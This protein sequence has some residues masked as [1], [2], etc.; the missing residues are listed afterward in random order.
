MVFSGI[1]GPKRLVLC[2]TENINNNQ[3][4]DRAKLSNRQFFLKLYMRIHP[5]VTFAEQTSQKLSLQRIVTDDIFTVYKGI[6]TRM[7]R[8]YGEA[9]I[10]D[11]NW[12]T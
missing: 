6:L 4:T 7:K 3:N 12:V 10:D 1:F 2:T 9:N 11:D 5:H 8:K